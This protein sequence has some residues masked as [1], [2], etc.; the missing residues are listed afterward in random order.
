MCAVIG[1]LVTMKTRHFPWVVIVLFLSC[2]CALGVFTGIG[3]SKPVTAQANGPILI[4]DE[5]S[6]RA[7]AFDSATHKH[8]P[9]SAFAP[10]LALAR[11]A[12]GLLMIPALCR[13]QARRCHCPYQARRQRR[14]H[15]R[16]T[17]Y[18]RSLLRRCRLRRR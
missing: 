2:L 17:K 7:I 14:G 11:L 6:T 12:M 5:L 4:S 3:G 10:G 15:W 13:L 8:E 9:F 16:P 18:E 1:A